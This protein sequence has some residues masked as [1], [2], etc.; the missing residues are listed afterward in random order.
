MVHGVPPPPPPRRK[1]LLLLLRGVGVGMLRG[2]G[3]PLNET[4]FKVWECFGFL[5]FLV[6]W[7]QSFKASKF[8]SFEDPK[9]LNVFGRYWSHITNNSISCFLEDIISYSRFS[10]THFMFSRRS[11][12]NI[13]DSKK[14][15][16]ESSGFVG[17]SL[18]NNFEIWEFRNFEISENII[19]KWFGVFIELFGVSWCFQR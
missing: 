1:A 19:F 7:F 2:R 6:S 16:D 14:V 15:Q 10:K 11:W 9:A 18:S 12:S 17:A 5:V 4:C 13:Q 8:Q 3:F